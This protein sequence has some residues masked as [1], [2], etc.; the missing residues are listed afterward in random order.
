MLKDLGG[1][2]SRRTEWLEYTKA[3]LISF[4]AFT[5]SSSSK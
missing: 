5:H 3:D 2:V 1:K 4:M